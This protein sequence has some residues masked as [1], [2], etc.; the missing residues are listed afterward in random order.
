MSNLNKRRRRYNKA[1]RA[2]LRAMRVRGFGI[3]FDLLEDYMEW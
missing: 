3:L 1:R 2:V